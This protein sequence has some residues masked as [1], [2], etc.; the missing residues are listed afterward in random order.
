MTALDH[1]TLH[2]EATVL[3]RRAHL[4]DPRAGLDGPGDLLVRDGEIVTRLD[5]ARR[6]AAYERAL[7]EVVPAAEVARD[8]DA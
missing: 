7:A 2:D 5:G 6:Q 4:L 3:V 1:G 8:R